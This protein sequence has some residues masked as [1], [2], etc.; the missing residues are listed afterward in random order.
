VG[1]G[2][3]EQ[4]AL[5]PV[6]ERDEPVHLREERRRVDDHAVADQ[7]ALAGAEDTAGHQ[8]QHDRAPVDDDAVPGVRSALVARHEVVL[9]GEHVHDLALP[10]VPPTGRRGPRCTA[11]ETPF[12]CT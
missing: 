2:A 6:A 8:V 3:D 12:S 7:A 1:L 5:E 10:L 4:P 11:C 9:G